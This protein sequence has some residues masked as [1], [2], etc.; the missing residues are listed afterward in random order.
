[1]RVPLSLKILG[2]FFLN[3][4]LLGLAALAF[5]RYQL[6]FGLDSFFVSQANERLTSVTRLIERELRSS[7]RENWHAVLGR[8]EAAYGVQFV[9][10]DSFQDQ[11]AGQTTVLPAEVTSRMRTPRGGPR[12]RF[13]PDR[14][15]RP[16][17][18]RRPRPMEPRPPE[19]IRAGNPQQYWT[20]ITLPPQPEVRPGPIYLVV[21]S[22]TLGAG[23]L[24]FESQPWILA[25][26]AVLVVSVL[27]WLPLVRGITR[28]IS[29]MTVVTKQIASGHFNAR[30]PAD[31]QDE[32]G[33]LGE[34]I[35]QMAGRL[36]GLIQGQK[37]FLGDT[38]HELVSP[39]AR[40]EM[41]LSILE[42]HILEKDRPALQDVHEEVRL[43]SGLVNELLSFS[44]A[45]LGVP[46]RKLS[47]IP[48]ADLVHRTLKREGVEDC[49]L[50]LPPELTVMGDAEL[51]QRA[52][53]NVVRNAQ[54]HAGG[55][56]PLQI[57][58]N[59]SG[60]KVTLSVADSGPGIPED[61][62]AKVFDPF[63]RVDVSRDRATGGTGLGLAITK[64]CVEACG[65]S[66]Q[67]RNRTP[68]GLE[69]IL[70]LNA[71]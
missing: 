60:G 1:M 12:D 57:S 67:C 41:G 14:E 45:S 44:K 63:F 3:L 11:I 65:G 31:R 47:P 16:E 70:T 39:L 68:T 34:S 40:M 9:L 10:F 15:P 62:L 32:L 52:V 38:A 13:Q 22:E 36:E 54:L 8:F 21:I 24:I 4:L 64:T 23:G 25:G 48:L 53:G 27:F 69:V 7:P 19:L 58:A 37:R 55:A 28:A 29:A 18:P 17:R 2:W 26:V 33:Q 46:N 35:N 43:M 42:Q 59:E 49:Q 51:L 61:A 56:G 50:N 6:H 5:F 71:A 30:A 66:V 20:L